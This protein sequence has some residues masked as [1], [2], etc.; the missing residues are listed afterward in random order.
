MIEI[1]N[2]PTVIR[3]NFKNMHILKDKTSD[4]YLYIAS[5]VGTYTFDDGSKS[6]YWYAEN[7]LIIKYLLFKKVD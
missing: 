1:D 7:T 5:N 3:D 6:W 4:P 2:K